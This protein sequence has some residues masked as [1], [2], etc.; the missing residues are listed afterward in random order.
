M[1]LVTGCTALTTLATLLLLQLPL[2]PCSL[3]S[4]RA[5]GLASVFWGSGFRAHGLDLAL[6]TLNSEAFKP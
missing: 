4:S 1:L 3:R 5:H 2:L 6:N